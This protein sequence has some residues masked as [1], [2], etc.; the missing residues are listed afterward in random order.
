MRRLWFS[1]Q[2]FFTPAWDTGIP[3]PELVRTIVQ[4]PPGHSLDIGCGTGTNLLYL[5]Q[6]RWTVTG[7]DYAAGAIAKA[8]RKLRNYSPVLLVA[9]ATKLGRLDL[10]GPYDLALDIGCFHSLTDEDRRG[11][12]EGLA[13]WMKSGGVFLLYAWQPGSAED[14]RGISREK[15]IRFFENEF[16][17][18][19]YEQGTG[20]PSA[21]Y[22]FIRK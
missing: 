1:F 6:H 21:W 14:R 15:T 2:Y 3:A 7:I 13:R 18:S 12:P 16:H 8:R 22:Y 5:A 10:P 4:L 17:L 11:Y 19:R 20:H 9:D